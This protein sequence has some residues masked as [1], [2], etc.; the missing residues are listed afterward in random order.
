MPVLY[1][2]NFNS[3]WQKQ[4]P[5]P[6]AIPKFEV[7]GFA[8]SLDLIEVGR[9]SVAANGGATAAFHY[10]TPKL[11]DADPLGAIVTVTAPAPTTAHPE[12]SESFYGTMPHTQRSPIAA[13]TLRIPF[14]CAD[15]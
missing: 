6:S 4:I 11:G 3:P 2:N 12:V 15:Q 10:P 5:G 9:L 7:I 1:V 8:S 13:S 14:A